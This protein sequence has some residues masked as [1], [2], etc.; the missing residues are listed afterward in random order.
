MEKFIELLQSL[1]RSATL[2]VILI[3]LTLYFCGLLTS[4][5]TNI[6]AQMPSIKDNKIGA[7]G[8]VSKEKNITKQTKWYFKPED[9]ASSESL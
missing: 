4:C 1:G 6:A 2:E 8:I 9:N 5:G 3:L 7:E